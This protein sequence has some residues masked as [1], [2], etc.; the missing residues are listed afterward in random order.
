MYDWKLLYTKEPEEFIRTLG[1]INKSIE[2][3]FFYSDR[4]KAS[5]VLFD[6]PVFNEK[7][8]MIVKNTNTEIVAGSMAIIPKDTEGMKKFI[9]EVAKLSE[10]GL[11]KVYKSNED[12]SKALELGLTEYKMVN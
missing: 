5:K 2:K 11:K 7:L 3:L 6:S 9:D 1:F 8:S 12:F 4:R 10:A